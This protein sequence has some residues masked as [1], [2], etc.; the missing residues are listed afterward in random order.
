MKIDPTHLYNSL[1]R[2][3]VLPQSVR[4]GLYLFKM[5]RFVP[6][7]ALNNPTSHLLSFLGTPLKF[8]PRTVLHSPDHRLSSASTY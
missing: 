7:S 8:H 1:S 4:S 3:S 2:I 5:L 6:F